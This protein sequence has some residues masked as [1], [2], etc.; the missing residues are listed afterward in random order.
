MTEDIKTTDILVLLVEDESDFVDQFQGA[1]KDINTRNDLPVTIALETVNTLGAAIAHLDEFFVD[2]V[3][4]DI[5]LPDAQGVSTI[6]AIT[7]QF[8]GIPVI[9]LIQVASWVEA[10]RSAGAGTRD[11]LLK[12]DIRSDEILRLSYHAY[13]QKQFNDQLMESQEAYKSLVDHLPEGVFRM[14]DQLRYTLVN[15]EFNRLTGLSTSLV[16]G[17]H[18]YELYNEASAAELGECLKQ[19]LSKRD[20]IQTEHDLTTVDGRRISVQIIRGPVIDAES[21]IIGIQGVMRDVTEHR[22]V[23]ENQRWSD[24]FEGMEALAKHIVHRVRD[25]LAPIA[26]TAATIKEKCTDPEIGKLTDMIVSLS[27]KAGESLQNIS[28]ISPTP[29]LTVMDIDLQLVLEN[30]IYFIRQHLP[31][32]VHL[33]ARIA[34]KLPSVRGDFG[35]LIELLEILGKNAWEA[36]GESG[37]ITLTADVIDIASAKS[38]SGQLTQAVRIRCEDTGPGISKESQKLIF[39]PYFTTKDPHQHS[40]TGLAKSMALAKQLGAELRLDTS[41][42][43][44]TAFEL[45]MAAE[46]PHTEAPASEDYRGSGQLILLVDDEESILNTEKL[47]LESNGF[48]TLSASNGAQG[49]SLYLEHSKEIDLV[50][51]DVTMPYLDGSALVNAIREENVNVPIFIITG[52]SAT[53]EPATL[54]GLEINAVIRKPFTPRDLLNKIHEALIN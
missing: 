8:P 42:K 46:S 53:S 24:R 48:R 31:P 36:V 12:R 22:K 32:D 50:I 7:E 20:W 17:K 43:K 34:D 29:L 15:K 9:S 40:G 26:L 10:I 28:A 19:A 18:D 51:T 5:T 6:Q 3:F 38:L 54:K 14:D 2:V 21:E 25:H 11:V 44:G 35:S 45:V 16:T 23:L 39:D 27:T 37:R 52:I 4:V 47:F 41:I 33:T 13:E 49:L 1:V 30:V